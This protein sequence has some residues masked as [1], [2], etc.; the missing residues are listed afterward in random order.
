MGQR[1]LSSYQGTHCRC[2]DL[3]QCSLKIRVGVD[4]RVLACVS[5]GLVELGQI[6]VEGRHVGDRLLVIGVGGAG[7]F[8]E[9]REENLV[10]HLRHVVE[11]A[12][13]LAGRLALAPVEPS[14]DLHHFLEKFPDGNFRRNVTVERA[15]RLERDR[16]GG[17]RTVWEDVGKVGCLGVGGVRA[18]GRMKE[19][20]F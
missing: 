19:T 10:H 5:T 18:K 1:G 8:F 6:G 15:S 7:L 20:I 14:F 13:L 12:S 9:R 16:V 4:L 17:G 3:L 2:D 11:K